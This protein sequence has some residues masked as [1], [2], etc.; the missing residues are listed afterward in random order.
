MS[1][2]EEQAPR[3]RKRPRRKKAPPNPVE[4]TALKILRKTAGLKQEQ[5]AA[6]AALGVSTYGKYERAEIQIQPANLRKLLQ[7]MDYPLRAWQDTLLLLEHLVEL[8]RRQLATRTE[9]VD[10]E[11]PTEGASSVSEAGQS[12]DW[13]TAERTAEWLAAQAGRRCEQEKLDTLLFEIQLFRSLSDR[14]R[15]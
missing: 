4:A 14:F 8:R 7:G 11:P 13:R 9:V 5:V 12:F 3:R 6:R 15:A 1:D 10:G 2:P